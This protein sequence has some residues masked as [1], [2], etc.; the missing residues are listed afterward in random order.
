MSEIKK[1]RES[2]TPAPASLD[3]LRDSLAQAPILAFLKKFD[4]FLK[5]KEQFLSRDEVLFEPGENPYLYIVSSGALGIY[6]LTPTGESKEIGRVYTGECI[7]EGIISGRNLKEVQASSLV[8][9]SR[10]VRL[11][12][13]DIEFLEKES[14]ET[15]AKFY[16]HIGDVTSQRLA[17]SGKE[18]ALMY[19]ST[20][21]FQ[22]FRE[23]GAKGLLD[24]IHHIR[25]MLGLRGILAIEE[26]PLVPDLF[27]YKYNTKFPT[28]WPLNQK[29]EPGI[30]LSHGIYQ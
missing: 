23:R 6:R 3:T 16:K 22:E 9:S 19:E 30:K 15:L 28:V 11:T 26:H 12:R 18:L 4:I 7:G 29:V 13:E 8:E 10:V 27:V 25:E 14:P 1:E 20:E 24:A 2:L 21:K 5:K 17:E